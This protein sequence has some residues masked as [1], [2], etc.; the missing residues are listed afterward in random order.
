M[1][2]AHPIALDLPF[3]GARDYLQGADIFNALIDLTGAQENMSLRLHALMHH[4][5]DAVPIPDVTTDLKQF[6]GVFIYGGPEGLQKIGLRD[7]SKIVTKRVPYDEPR[8]IADAS[9]HDH[10]IVSPGPS[11]FTFMERVLALN[12]ALLQDIIPIEGI[13]WLATRLDLTRVPSS[14]MTLAVEL[15]ERLGTRLTKSSIAVDG[16]DVGFVYFSGVPK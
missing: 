15:V 2:L 14:P 6:A 7:N 10:R 4:G 12:K 5:I 1:K 11:E 13:R 8:V 16:E 9:V 3:R